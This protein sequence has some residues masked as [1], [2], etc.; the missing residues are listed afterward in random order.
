MEKIEVAL[1]AVEAAGFK[2]EWNEDLADREEDPAPWYW[3]LDGDFRY[4]NTVMDY[5]TVLRMTKLGRGTVHKFLGFFE[6]LGVIP[7]GTQKTADSLALAA[8]CL[9]AGGKAKLHL[10]FSI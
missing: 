10:I 5:L 2:L 3:P 4:C 1:K 6:T 8:D 9:V 7:T